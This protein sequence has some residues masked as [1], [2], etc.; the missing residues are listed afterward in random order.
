M[1]IYNNV[2]TRFLKMGARQF[3]QDCHRD[4]HLKKSLALRKSLMLRREKARKN[5]MKVHLVQIEQYR[6]PRESG[7]HIF[8]YWLL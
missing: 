3:L 8:V 4:Y 7:R 6:I 5:Q 1:E 2:I